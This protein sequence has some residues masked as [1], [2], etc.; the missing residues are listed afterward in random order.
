MQGSVPVRPIFFALHHKCGNVYF[1]QVIN[2]FIK[3]TNGYRFLGATAD[4][5]ASQS[6]ESRSITR[7]RNFTLPQV[8]QLPG[9]GKVVACIRDPRS[10]IVSCTDYH[11]RGDEKAMQSPIKKFGG[12]TYSERLAVAQDD[13]E[14]LIVSM[15]SKAGH[16]VGNMATF[17]EADNDI[18]VVRLE[19]IVG[20]E[21]CKV[22]ETIS[23]FLELPE[24][25]QKIM[26]EMLI[27]HSLWNLKSLSRE[28]PSHSTSGVK[29]D[30]IARIKG[31]ALSKYEELFGDLHI[32][33]GYAA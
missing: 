20:D 29:S 1:S 5:L 7:L 11:L 27:R 16:I 33:L 17:A 25:D 21:S 31:E 10:L 18:L 13:E 8:Q 3:E 26:T 24:N 6:F 22:Y 9:N 15:E 23:E 4:D 2:D 12:L 32:R 30:S 19:D 28:L 14:R